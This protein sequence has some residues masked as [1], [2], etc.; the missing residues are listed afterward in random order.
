MDRFLFVFIRLWFSNSVVASFRAL[1]F[2]LHS[3]SFPML[4]SLFSFSL[5]PHQYWDSQNSTMAMKESCIYECHLL[6]EF[7]PQVLFIELI[8][9]TI[10]CEV[11][12]M[13]ESLHIS[14]L[15]N[16][17]KRHFSLSTVAFEH[18]EKWKSANKNEGNVCI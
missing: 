18:K 2:Q 13:I 15:A 4:P 3:L 11:L 7:N 10:I 6:C 16:R 14:T 5:A 17:R 9:N 1:V 8:R 12:A